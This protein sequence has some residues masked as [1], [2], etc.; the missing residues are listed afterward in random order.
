MRYTYWQVALFWYN[1]A[2]DNMNN[3]TA[4]S[5]G[6]I[7]SLNAFIANYERERDA[8]R[9]RERM[10][11]ITHYA[12]LER[13]YERMRSTFAHKATEFACDVVEG[14]YGFFRACAVGL[15][16]FIVC[17]AFMLFPAIIG[18]LIEYCL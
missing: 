1:T 10:A 11:C 7:D 18:A 12:E 9:E 3:T 8:R 4:I 17:V 5:Q 15:V 2:M 6:S 14:V 13:N 16:K